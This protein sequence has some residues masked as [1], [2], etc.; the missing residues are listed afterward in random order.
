MDQWPGEADSAVAM[1]P[2]VT[3][4]AISK[5]LI[6]DD[7][8]GMAKVI[9]ATASGLGC[10]TQEVSDARLATAAFIEFRPDLLVLDLVMPGK[11]GL[12]V[13]NEVLV[14]DPSVRLVLI[15][16][17]GDGYLRLGEALTR[18]HRDGG[19]EILRKPFRAE[20]LRDVLRRSL[21]I[22]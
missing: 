17:H 1:A 8:R 2:N 7:E 6:V 12:D 19:A 11:D 5:V 3:C 9:A 13:L 10:E 16:G 21:E 18:F 14:V 15:S 22:V 20:A 4:K